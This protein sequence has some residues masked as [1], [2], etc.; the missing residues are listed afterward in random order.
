VLPD[1]TAADLFM[2]EQEVRGQAALGRLYEGG[3]R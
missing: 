3:G 2:T 1:E